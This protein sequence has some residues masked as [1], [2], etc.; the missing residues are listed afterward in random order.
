M[1]AH[2]HAAMMAEYAKDATKT[3]T[4][5]E[6]WQFHAAERWIDCD[7]T[8]LW[9]EHKE[10]RRKPRTIK[11]NGHDVPKPVCSKETMQEGMKYYVPVLQIDSESVYYWVDSAG[12][13]WRLNHGLVH[14]TKEAAQ[15]HSEALISITH[16]GEI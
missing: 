3:E 8:P 10:Y 15:A 16:N 2:K 5:W 7:C 14:L 13:N 11:I 9:R 4:P 1:P 12:D 6:L